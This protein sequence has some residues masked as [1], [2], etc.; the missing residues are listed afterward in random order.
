MTIDVPKI[1]RAGWNRRQRRWKPN[2][3]LSSFVRWLRSLT[4]SMPPAIPAAITEYT[5]H[6]NKISNGVNTPHHV[7]PVIPSNL[8]MH[9]GKVKVDNQKI[10]LS[11]ILVICY[12][13]HC[14]CV[15]QGYY[16]FSWCRRY[17]Q[18]LSINAIQLR[19]ASA[20]YPTIFNHIVDLCEKV[21]LASCLYYLIMSVLV[22]QS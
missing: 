17:P 11:I 15:L 18:R 1:S 4:A 2:H 10:Y 3:V 9:R 16:N 21:I 5:H 7:N 8:T 12:G 6:A 13:L 19:S 22:H 14:F 20:R